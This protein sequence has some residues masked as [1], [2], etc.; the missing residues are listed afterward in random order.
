MEQT[1]SHVV[2]TN[3]SVLNSTTLLA[4]PSQPK[5][6]EGKKVPLVGKIPVVISEADVQVYVDATIQLEEPALE[7]TR[8][9]KN[10]FLTR[11][12]LLLTDDKKSAKLLISGFVRNCIE[13]ST[14]KHVGQSSVSG[15]IRFTVVNIPFKCFT[16]VDFITEPVTASNPQSSTSSAMSPDGFGSD[17]FALSIT[18]SEILNEKIYCELIESKIRQVDLKKDVE[19][20][21]QACGKHT[22]ER[23]F[24]AFLESIV[25]EIKL[26]VMQNQSVF[27]SP[28]AAS[29]DGKAGGGKGSNDGG[30]GDND[31]GKSDNDCGKGDKDGGKDRKDGK[32]E[33]NGGK[34]RKDDKGEDNEGKRDK[35]EE[36][37]EQKEDSK[38]D[39]RSDENDKEKDNDD[40]DEDYSKDDYKE[41]WDQQDNNKWE[42]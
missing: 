6:V 19:T 41:S 30:K 12:Q 26:R 14:A 24:K 29:G 37:N 16:K 40:K 21:T 3:S 4:S 33:D 22:N 36:N 23:T 42:N 10:V 35:A 34:D 27:I 31:G 39:D 32:G 25:I 5:K 13:Y 20:L 1:T 28:I 11:S 38:K 17:Q 9:K 18:N 2:S 15:K 8:V 7:I